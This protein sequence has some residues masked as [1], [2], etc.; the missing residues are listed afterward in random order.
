MYISLPKNIIF[1]IPQAILMFM[2]LKMIKP[3][4]KGRKI[5]PERLLGN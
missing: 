3:I 4:L 5:V 2:F 1:L